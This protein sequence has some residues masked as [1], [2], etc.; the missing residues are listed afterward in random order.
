MKKILCVLMTVCL[1][2]CT[3]VFPAS[4]ATAEPTDT[5][6]PVMRFVAC[7][8]THVSDN[9]D[10][11]TIRI[12]KMMAKAYEIAGE[13]PNYTAVDALL[14]AGDL[15]NDGTATEFRKFWNAVDGALQDGTQFL[16]IVAKNHDG[17]D[18]GRKE[19]RNLFTELSGCDADFHVVIGGYHFIGLSASP[20]DAMHY[21]LSQLTW[22]KKQLDAA[23]AEDP[24]KPV[25]VTHHEHVRGTVYGSSFYDGWGVPYFKSI[26][27]GYPQVVDLSGHSHYPL[28]DPR[29]VWQEKFTA[30]GTGA[31]YYSEFTI[32]EI[33]AYDPPDCYET[34][35][36]WIIE[37]DADHN[38]RLRGLD[39]D[40][41]R[42]LCDFI[43]ENP[44]DPENRSFTKEARK[45]VAAAPAFAEG[46]LISVQP[47]YG[48]CNIV[49]PVAESVDGMPVVLYRA[50]AMN[51][52]EVKLTESWTLPQYYR[53]IDLDEIELTL[54]DLGEGD[55]IIR[56]V[57]EN[58][59]G[60]QSEPLDARVKIDGTS[61]YL[62]VFTYL[63][64][65][66]N[67][68]AYFLKELF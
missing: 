35:T 62:S 7:S 49:A 5:F 27:D 31:I 4:A 28:N 13:D 30:I 2:A 18:M 67:R 29:S 61:K 24:T 6:V 48:G 56:V 45:A 23:T 25:F 43:M 19:Y 65:L 34:G 33:R 38:M 52:R 15:T 3:F 39:V 54:N 47:F 1:L 44:A 41:G 22:L 36:C 59:Y 14:I 51:V 10:M 12:G 63:K 21:D 57:A 58:A 9:N 40:E 11:T 50:Y 16:G 8:D 68:I 55:Y 42:F 53:A 26:L 66:F 17:W 46:A 64:Q 20:N 60:M 32:D 37:L